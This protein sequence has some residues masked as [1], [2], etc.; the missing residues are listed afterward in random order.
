[1]LLAPPTCIA[2][3][4]KH[5]AHGGPFCLECG[6]APAVKRGGWLSAI[7]RKQATATINASNIA[8]RLWIGGAPPIA[9]DMPKVDV[10]VLCAQEI[11]PPAMA[12]HGTVL[13]CPMPDGHL[14]EA[15]LR[16][17]LSISGRVAQQLVA[18]RRVLVTCAQGINRSALVAAL[19]LG[20]MTRMSADE[21][22][23][24][25]RRRR[26]PNCL[27]NAHFRDI[28]QRFVGA[29]RKR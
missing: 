25:M 3:G 16:Q 2:P 29:G 28:L 14:S 21:L 6:K 1:M 19:A 9:T 10:L 17:A 23:A 8:S 13:R 18:K 12:F 22:V 5:A 11:Q 4:C 26:H 20:R 7:K 24:L 27:Y 15:E